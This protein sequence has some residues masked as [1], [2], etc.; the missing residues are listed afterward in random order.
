M[1]ITKEFLLIEIDSLEQEIAKSQTYIS[2][3]QAVISA[4]KML[5]NRIEAPEIGE[6][7]E[8]ESE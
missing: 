7:L 6:A 4:Y 1:Q 8:V 5:V 2:Q 3:C